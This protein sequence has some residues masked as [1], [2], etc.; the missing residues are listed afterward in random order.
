M[1]LTLLH[2]ADWHLGLRFR[3]FEPEQEKRLTRARLEVV[4]R[5]LDVAESRRVD[6]VLCAGDLFNEEDPGELWWGEVL[7]ELQ[8]KERRGWQRPVVLLPGNHDPL[9]ANSIYHEE[10]RFRRALPD[11]VKVVDRPGWELPLGDNAVVVASPC[12]SAAGD[13]KLVDSL[14]KREDGDKRIRIGLIHGQTFDLPDHQTNFPIPAGSASALGLDYL[15][16]GDT[17]AF[18]D[19]EP[20]APAPTVYPGAPE[21]T[22]F[23]EQDTGH[24]ALV[25]FPLDRRRRALVQKERVGSWTWRAKPCHSLHDLRGLMDETNLA[26]MVLRLTLDMTVPMGEYDEAERLLTELGGSEAAGPR[27]GVLQV[28]REKLRLDANSDDDLEDLPAVLQATKDRLLRLANDDDSP[29]REQAE[30]A[31][32]HLYRLVREAA[33]AA[34]PPLQPNIGRVTG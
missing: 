22:K 25:F 12:T 24:V 15:A 3:A 26:N 34:K 13:T 10:H 23:D 27:A 31:L 17:H 33:R 6:A 19:V 16:I 20:N 11:F 4:T 14:P 28:H 8:R 2:T 1:A 21:A 7:N 32:H 9:T 29:Q 30:R 18:R 5:I